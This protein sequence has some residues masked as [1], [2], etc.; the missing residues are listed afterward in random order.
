MKIKEINQRIQSLYSKGASSDDSRLSNRFLYS[1]ILT[2]RALL[3]SQEAKKKQRISMWNYQTIPC[4]ELIEVPKN[5]CP[6]IPPR[7]CS[8]YRSRHK[9]PEPLVGLS[10]ALIQGVYDMDGTIKIDEQNLNS[11][12][13]NSGNKYATKEPKYFIESGYLYL[14]GPKKLPIVKMVA[15]FEDPIAVKVF[16]GYCDNCKDCKKCLDYLEEEFPLDNDMIDALVRLISEEV[17]NIFL[18]NVDDKRN[19]TKD[20]KN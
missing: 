14:V 16:E 19:D 4:I 6:C 12:R 18:Q 17:L 11:I 5:E 7:G 13:F 8:I 9:I 20:D 2:T 15:L 10:G 3:L 1:K